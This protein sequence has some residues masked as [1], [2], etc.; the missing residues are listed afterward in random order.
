MKLGILNH[1]V[2]NERDGKLLD[3]H[4]DQIERHTKV[5]YTIYATVN[6]LLP[7]FRVKM[8]RHQKVKICEC[9]NVHLPVGEDHAFYLEHLIQ[10]AIEDGCTHIAILHVDSFPVRSDWVEELARKL[11]ESY[12]FAAPYYGAYTACLFFQRDFY[13]KYRPAFFIPEDERSSE[14]Y[15]M[16]CKRFEH[17]PHAGAGYLFKAYSEELP[18]YPLRESNK[19][20]VHYGYFCSIYED[21]IFHLGAVW[22]YSQHKIHQSSSFICVRTWAWKYFW[23]PIFRILLSG[24]Q[25]KAVGA[26]RFLIPRHLMSWGWKH[27]GFPMF[28]IPILWHERK[29]LLEDPESYLNYLRTG[30]RRM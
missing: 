3:L 6:V 23:F 22:T 9:P 18:W 11:S 28:F 29:Q 24:T 4:L 26:K 10:E 12:V 2:V 20:N 14:K 1:Y 27:L 25:Q 16:F 5:P 13:L 8:E 15:R 19:G 30:K 21:L 7:Q 17:I